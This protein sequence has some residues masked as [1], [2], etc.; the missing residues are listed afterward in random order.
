MEREGERTPRERRRWSDAE[1]RAVVASSYAPGMSVSKASRLHNVNANQI[2]TWRRR[3]REAG[4][5]LPS[6][7]APAFA[8]VDL[9][10]SATPAEPAPGGAMEI[11]TLDG[12]RVRVWADVDGSAL[13]RVLA[14]IRAVG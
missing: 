4:H 10:R 3:L 13:S 14:A 1:R 9:V 2:F 8:V 5:L 6:P 11:E 7:D 12:V